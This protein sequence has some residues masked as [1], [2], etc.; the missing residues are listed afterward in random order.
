MA[1]IELL[2]ALRHKILA[3]M[4]KRAKQRGL[5]LGNDYRT[6][7]YERLDGMRARREALGTPYAPPTA[8][9]KADLVNYLTATAQRHA[10][11]DVKR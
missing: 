1:D 9:E 2:K 5:D 7:L 6:L 3:E 11:A 8:A 4:E 10:A